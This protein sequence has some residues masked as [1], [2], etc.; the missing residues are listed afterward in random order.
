MGMGGPKQVQL[1]GLDLKQY[2]AFV[3]EWGGRTWV[4]YI[5]ISY[6]YEG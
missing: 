2:K 5:I 6:N 3:F 4:N 1:Q